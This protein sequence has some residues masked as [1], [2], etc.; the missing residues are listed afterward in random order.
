ALTYSLFC[1]I[2]GRYFLKYNPN[3]EIL[4]KES[5]VL[6]SLKEEPGHFI[7]QGDAFALRLSK[8]DLSILDYTVSENTSLPVTNEKAITMKILLEGLKN[9]T[10]KS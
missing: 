2:E 10:F 3:P 1:S 4:Y 7:F 8:N 9:L 5:G 6:Y